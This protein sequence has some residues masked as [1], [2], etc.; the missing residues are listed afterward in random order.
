[1]AATVAALAGL[2]AAQQRAAAAARLCGAAA[3]VLERIGVSR[4]LYFDQERWESTHLALRASL[5]EEAFADAWAEG[6]ALSL[7]AAV[8]LA[9]ER[10]AAT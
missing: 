8:A 9:L 5:G 2:L 6:R 7:D 3:I 10:T 1:M 4:L